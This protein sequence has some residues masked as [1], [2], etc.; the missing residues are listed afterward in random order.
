[1]R[2]GFCKLKRS[3]FVFI[4]LIFVAGCMNNSSFLTPHSSLYKIASDFI[5]TPY[6]LDPLGEGAGAPIDSDPIYRTDVFDCTTFV[7]TVLARATGTDLQKIRY[8]GGRIDWFNRNHWMETEW[9]PNAVELGL[10]TP[11]RYGHTGRTRAIVDMNAWVRHRTGLDIY[12]YPF[13]MSMR[14]IPR[15]NFNSYMVRQMPN[16]SVIFFVRCRINNDFVTGDMITHMGLLFG[17]YMIHAGR[18][19][20][21]QKINVVEYIRTNRQFCGVIIYEIV[22]SNQ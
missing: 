15:A 7:E 9:I 8:Q 5:G 11:V 16:P 13:S 10:I 14:M 12:S 19:H 1:M 6:Q 22:N 2:N 20:G 4:A 3:V 18:A 17:E 21:V